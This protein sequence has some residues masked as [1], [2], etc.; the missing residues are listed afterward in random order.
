MA[1][2]DK[3]TVRNEVSRLKAE[4]EQLCADGK[5]N[6]EIK[7]LMNSMFMIIELML[8]I[9]LERV[10]KKN[11]KNSSIPSS[12]TDKDESALPLPAGS[13][14]KGKQ[15]N[16][17]TASNTRVNE[18]VTL[19]EVHACDVCGEDLTGVASGECERR[20]R[21]DIIFEKVVEHVDAE[22]KRC[23]HVVRPQ[24]KARFPLDMPGPC[25]MAT[26]LRPMP[27]IYW[28]VR[29]SHLIGFRNC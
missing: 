5:I 8:S 13:K 19:S 7:I 16:N 10:T 25:S 27:S 23:P 15:E 20:T 2:L 11:N 21:I 28:F 3:T 22:I 1:S 18:S 9:F 17:M 6:N 12:Q 29:W 14:R 4:F 26:V 24:S